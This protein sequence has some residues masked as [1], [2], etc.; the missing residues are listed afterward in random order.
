MCAVQYD[1]DGYSYLD[2][3]VCSAVQYD[4][5]VYSYLDSDVYSTIW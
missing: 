1:S 2:S 3:D 4:S 5:D